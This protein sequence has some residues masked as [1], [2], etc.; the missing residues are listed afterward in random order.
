MD[1]KK[2][3][4]PLCLISAIYFLTI[5]SNTIISIFGLDGLYSNPIARSAEFTIGVSFSEIV[6]TRVNST[7]TDSRKQIFDRDNLQ[8]FG[9]MAVILIISVIVAYMNNADLR[10]ILF[11]YLVVPVI[12]MFLL[13]SMITR[14][15]ILEKSRLLSVLS[16]VAYQFFLMQLFLWPL[17]TKAMSILKLEGN[18]AKIVISFLLCLT[19]SYALWRFFDKPV[20]VMLLKIVNLDRR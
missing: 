15:S 12:L 14:V 9:V 11:V 19:S 10:S 18:M 16:G 6:S 7:A 13:M 2:T 1:S 8:L 4:I 3:W 17:S 20:R 5:Y